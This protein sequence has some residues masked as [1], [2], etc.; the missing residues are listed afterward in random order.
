MIEFMSFRRSE[1]TEESRRYFCNKRLMNL[2][3]SKISIVHSM[4]GDEFAT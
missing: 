3:G 4:V 2:V 1:A